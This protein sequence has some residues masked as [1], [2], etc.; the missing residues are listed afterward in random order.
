MTGQHPPNLHI[1]TPQYPSFR[2][3][4]DQ[5]RDFRIARTNTRAGVMA[6]KGTVWITDE[7]CPVA[8]E[9]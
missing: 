6:F 5:R 1:T 7:S 9:G 2:F 4:D 3:I 8:V